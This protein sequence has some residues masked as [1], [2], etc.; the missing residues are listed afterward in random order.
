[1][2]QY[3]NPNDFKVPIWMCEYIGLAKSDNP[4]KMFTKSVSP[5]IFG[6]KSGSVYKDLKTP[7]VSL[8]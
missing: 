2:S 6:I 5:R 4:Q 7:T 1:M 3:P 8:L